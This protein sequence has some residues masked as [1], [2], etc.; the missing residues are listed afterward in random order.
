[1]RSIMHGLLS[2]SLGGLLLAGC[3]ALPTEALK[4][5]TQTAE[6]RSLQTR[7]Y[8]G[9]P[10]AT[11][12]SAGLGVLQDLG[13]TL[14]SSESSLGVISASRKLTSHRPLNA[15]EA[16]A[17]LLYAAMLPYLAGPMMVYKTAV[18]VKEPQIVHVCLVTQPAAGGAATV[19]ITAQRRLYQDERLTQLLKVEPLNDPAFYREFFNRLAKSVS[20]EELKS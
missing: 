10:E 1:M 16:V 12:L 20:L 8:A 2:V 13:F 5:A 19:R 15:N 9:A 7:R 11:M 14:D 4:L 18:G 6:L 17:G 3:T